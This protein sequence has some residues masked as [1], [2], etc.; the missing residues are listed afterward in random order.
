MLKMVTDCIEDGK[1][2][3]FHP[4]FPKLPMTAYAYFCLRLGVN[5]FDK[6]PENIQQIYHD[7]DSED[8]KESEAEYA[9]DRDNYC[10]Q[11]LSK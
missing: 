4:K 5:K 9:K 1:S 8:V 10:Q 3:T 6:I 2:V 11:V 7:K